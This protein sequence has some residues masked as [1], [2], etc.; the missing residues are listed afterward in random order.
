LPIAEF[1]AGRQIAGNCSFTSPGVVLLFALGT[2]SEPRR[3]ILARYE[4]GLID[5]Q[6]R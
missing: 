2:Q 3:T 5:R 6:V 1:A 4:P